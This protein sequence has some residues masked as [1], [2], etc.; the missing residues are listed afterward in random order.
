MFGFRKKQQNL[1][2]SDEGMSIKMNEREIESKKEYVNSILK[3]KKLPIVLLDPLWLTAKEHIKSKAISKAEKELQELLKQ[4]A[5]LNTDYKEYTV[6]K[7]NFL[8]D[9]LVA[10]GKAQDA[11]N[12]KALDE[13]NKLHQ[14]TLGANQKL[15]EI[16]I[17]LDTLDLEI[18]DKNRAIISEMVAIGYNYIDS[19][20]AQSDKI[21]AEIAA[22]RE[23]MLKKTNQKKESDA[24][25]KQMYNY[26]HSIVGNEQIEVIDRALGDKR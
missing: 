18:E 9:I 10:S 23:E 7:Q 24:F 12:S 8:K 3:N 14:T 17:K 19:Y 11:T 16:E 21:E 15:E 13:L 22:L 26:I 20:K 6:L 25:L 5:R 4:Q 2:S 1:A